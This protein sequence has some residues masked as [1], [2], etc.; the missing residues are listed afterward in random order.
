LIYSSSPRPRG[1]EL[2]GYSCG[3]FVPQ[4]I[5][6]NQPCGC[7]F[8]SQSWGSTWWLI[9][10]SKWVITTVISGLPLLIPFITGVITH[11]L[12][13]MS[14]QVWL[15]YFDRLFWLNPGPCDLTCWDSVTGVTQKCPNFSEW[16][17]DFRFR[18]LDVM[19]LGNYLGWN[20][21]ESKYLIQRKFLRINIW[22]D[23]MI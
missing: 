10:L 23:Q 3:P 21:T 7:H 9:P 8:T 5:Q 16:W 12:T 13:G 2:P 15:I 19:T 20:L 18:K 22:V 17:H 1:H 11:L 14:H 6:T 4:T